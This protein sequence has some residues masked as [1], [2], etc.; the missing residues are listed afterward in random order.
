[1][2]NAELRVTEPVWE[3]EVDDG[4]MFPSRL[5]VYEDPDEGPLRFLAVCR[6]AWGGGAQARR[7]T[8]VEA[9]LHTRLLHERYVAG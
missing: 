6:G 4:G 5:S 1:M 8:F 9:C 2:L 7:A 3:Q